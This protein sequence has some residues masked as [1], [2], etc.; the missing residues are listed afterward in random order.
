MRSVFIFSIVIFSIGSCA[1]KST[2]AASENKT[3]TQV[4]VVEEVKPAPIV[5]TESSASIA[6]HLTYD[7]KCGR[8]HGLK[9]VSDYTAKQ[10]EPIIGRMAPRARLDST[11]KINVLAY[12]SFNAKS[13]N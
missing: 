7:A 12:V 5:V 13:G 4:Q 3:A 10:W 8:C 11:E 6:G 9:N 2:P 1:K